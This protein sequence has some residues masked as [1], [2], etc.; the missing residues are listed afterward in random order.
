M[1][2]TPTP[3]TDEAA[4]IEADVV[5]ASF[6]RQLETELAEVTRQRDKYFEYWESFAADRIKKH[7]EL[8]K[9]TRQRDE[10]KEQ[11][12][13][14]RN[15]TLICA[16]CDAVRKIEYDEAIRQRDELAEALIAYREALHD[17]P[18]NCTYRRYE[19]VDELAKQALENHVRP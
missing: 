1:N 19:E 12:R 9:T 8:I 4:W 13:L 18:D 5:E 7:K 16:D 15:E 11:N 3:R 10:L 2:N 14:F 17:G 6:A